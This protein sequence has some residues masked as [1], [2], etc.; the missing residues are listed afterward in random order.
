MSGKKE[1]VCFPKHSSLD[2]GVLLRKLNAVPY[3]E[4]GP[5]VE[6]TE[7]SGPAPLSPKALG[8][9]LLSWH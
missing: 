8:R 7:Q 6:G 3:G 1:L 2:L 5:G 9:A 4:L